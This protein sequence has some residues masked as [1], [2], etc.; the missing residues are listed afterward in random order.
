LS[1]LTPSSE[2]S[3]E[4]ERTPNLAILATRDAAGELDITAVKT[5][6]KIECRH[7]QHATS[8]AGPTLAPTHFRAGGAM[9]RPLLSPPVADI[10]R[11]REGVSTWFRKKGA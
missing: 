8:Q 11:A 6:A 1:R 3:I 2:R 9:T 4:P 5:Q 10:L 7:L